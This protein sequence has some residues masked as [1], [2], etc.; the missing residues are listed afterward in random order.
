MG[1]S[2][3]P[4]MSRQDRAKQFMPFAALKGYEEE[5]KK[6][7]KIVVPRIELSEERKEELDQQFAKLKKK[8]IVTAIY[9]CKG[10]YLK[11]TGMIS[12]I[13]ADARLL[14]IVST[15]IPFEDLYEITLEKREEEKDGSYL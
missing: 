2:V 9:F 8:D 13:D 14:V 12:R 15:K 1:S 11:V 4:K 3:R 7:E 5:L 6:R 10:E